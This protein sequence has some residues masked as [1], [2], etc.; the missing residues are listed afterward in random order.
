MAAGTALR[1]GRVLTGAGCNPGAILIRDGRI[2]AV[3]APH[4]VPAGYAVEDFD[5]LVLM[6]GIV[7]SHVHVNEPGRTEWEG[8]ATATAA[9]AAGG[10]TTIVDMPLNSIPVTTTLAALAEKRAAAA[11]RCHV[12]T[13]FWGGVVPGNASE[14]AAMIDAGACGF[15]AFLVHSG[16]DDFPCS[17]EADLRQA[18]AVLGPRGI[19][20]LAHA[21][22]DLGA[23]HAATSSPAAYATFLASRPKAWENAAIARLIG[24]A[25][26]FRAPVH[27]VHLSSDEAL[28]PLQA[29]RARSVPISVETCP[30]YLTFDAEGI[31]DG[32]TEFKCAP[33]IRER[34]NRERLWA[35]LADGTIDMVVSDHS[36]CVPALKAREAGDFMQAWGGIASLQFALSAT[37]TG[38]EARGLGFPDLS[39]LMAAAPARL[40]G[41]DHRKGRLA[42]GLDADVVAFDPDGSV[43]VAQD[44]IRHRHALTPYLGRTLRGR[45]VATF[46]RGTRVFGE[47]ALA[48]VAPRGEL[49]ERRRHGLR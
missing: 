30:H 42:A 38:A 20:L 37:W 17:A 22:E 34:A 36:P 18:L 45:V 28:A 13:A 3:T 10:I 47:G 12:D 7:D 11:G 5:P 14:L 19:P 16:I 43:V 49:L 25:E 6:P 1:S 32:A 39:R 4:E 2:D 15:K 33:P 48:D 40:A 23:P 27:V 24:L 8:F 46:V 29:A 35:A 44:M 26:E 31:A 41:L 9:A 21:E